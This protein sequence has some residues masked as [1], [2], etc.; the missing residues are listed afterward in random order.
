MFLYYDIALFVAFC[1]LAAIFLYKKRK[2]IKIESKIFFLYRTKFGLAFVERLAKKAKGFFS[3]L[4]VLSII[5][6]FVGM[7]GI[8]F[9]LLFSLYKT[10]V[11]PQVIS[12]PP[13]MPLVPWIPIPGMPTLYFTFWIVAIALLALVHEGMHA[14]FCRINKIRLKSS[15]FGF[16]GPIPIA[17]V[18]PDEKQLAKKSKKEQLSVFSAGPFGNFLLALMII[19]IISIVMNPLFLSAVKNSDVVIASVVNASPAWNAGLKAGEKIIV[20]NATNFLEF[21]NFVSDL[22]PNQTVKIRANEREIDLTTAANPNNESVAY[23]G[24]AVKPLLKGIA[25]ILPWF[26]A[27]LFWIF[28][29]NL[30]VGLFNLL[31]FTI[32]DGGRL[33]YVASLF[34]INKKKAKDFTKIASSVSLMLILLNIFVWFVRWFATKAF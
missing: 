6:G 16:F 7:L 22:K 8:F 15:G 19:L 28:A 12:T 1:I 10:A 2:K 20:G 24:I 33:F 29:T 11:M 3:F 30:F 23:I 27:L 21:A 31:P 32:T 13:I 26:S 14:V 18:E 17:F 5:T 25:N 9:L 4:S 34:F